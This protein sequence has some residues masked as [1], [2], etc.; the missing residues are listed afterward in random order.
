MG[1][2]EPENENEEGDVIIVKWKMVVV[3][4]GSGHLP[5]GSIIRGE[6]ATMRGIGIY[7]TRLFTSPTEKPVYPAMTPCTAFWASI[8]Q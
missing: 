3:Q 7:T 4:A 1:V 6:V 8:M 2:G 5:A